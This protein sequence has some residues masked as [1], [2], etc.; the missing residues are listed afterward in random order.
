MSV[1][2]SIFL[3]PEDNLHKYQWILTKLDV[4]I[5]IEEIWFWTANGQ[6]SSIFDSCLLPHDSGR[7]LSFH[8]FI[9]RW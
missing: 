9:F 8:I 6:I 4:C 7:V 5:D 1:S 2:L 3:F